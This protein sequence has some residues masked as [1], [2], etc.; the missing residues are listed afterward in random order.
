MRRRTLLAVAI[1]AGLGA[2][3]GA[4]AREQNTG[5]IEL[6]LPLTAGGLT[7]ASMRVLAEGLADVLSRQVLVVN[8][9]GAAGVIALRQVAAAAPDGRTLLAVTSSHTSVLPFA[10]PEARLDIL[11]DFAPVATV[12][13]S[14]SVL[15]VNPKVPAQDL[16]GFLDHAKAR[17]GTLTYGTAGTG[18]FGHAASALLFQQAGVELAMVPYQGGS[19]FTTA[20][21]SGEI[22]SVF[23]L[24]SSTLGQ[25]VKDGRLRALGMSFRQASELLDGVPPIADTLPGFEAV[26]WTGLLAPAG[27]DPK[28]IEQLNQAIANVLERPAVRE[29]FAQMGVEASAMT[30]TAYRKAILEEQRRWQPLIQTLGLGAGS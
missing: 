10:Q 22:D 3:T 28:V 14:P 19:H 23:T 29:R 24:P 15:Y 20:L 9:P 12:T 21:V 6:I 17:P 27:T 7:D 13:R 26:V 18:S 16:Q 11:R 4:Q 1:C 2:S 25:Y 8:K 5:P 30:P